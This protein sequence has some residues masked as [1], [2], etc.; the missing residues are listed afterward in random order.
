MVSEIRLTRIVGRSHKDWG[1]LT[2]DGEDDYV[3]VAMVPPHV[4][5]AFEKLIERASVCETV[6]EV[7]SDEKS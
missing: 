1:N 4:A 7:K 3:C 2:Y 5:T 6:S